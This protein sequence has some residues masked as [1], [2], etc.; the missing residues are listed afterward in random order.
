MN[1]TR[2]KAAIFRKKINLNK[3]LIKINKIRN[4]IIKTTNKKKFMRLNT[5]KLNKQ[6]N[7]KK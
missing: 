1:L 5:L 3:D 6:I 2:K 7:Q 4:T